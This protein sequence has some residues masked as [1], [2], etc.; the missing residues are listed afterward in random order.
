MRTF[1]VL[2]AVGCSSTIYEDTDTDAGPADTSDPDWSAVSDAFDAA[3]PNA[4]DTGMTLVLW[5]AD[6]QVVY[7]RTAGGFE[8]DVRVPVASASKLVSALLLL[9]MVDQGQLSLTDTTGEVLGWTGQKRRISLDHLGGFTS[10]FEGTVGC[11]YNATLSLQDCTGRM[12]DAGPE[13]QPGALFEYTNTHLHIAGA[14]AEV[15]GGAS[16]NALFQRDLAKPLGLTSPDLRYYTL[17]KRLLG[18]TNPL[19]AGGMVSSVDE[20]GAFLQLILN[21]GQVDGA[22]FIRPDL[23]DRLFTNAYTDA[24]IGSS[25]VVE[26]G[27]DY[28]YGFG[29]W[30]ECEG[31]PAQCDILNSAGSFGF[32]PW[33]DRGRGYAGI[34]AMEGDTGSV[35]TFGLPLQQ[36]LRPLIEAV[37]DSPAE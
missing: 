31:A 37:L 35:L 19:V 4:P 7:R 18:D 9:R 23:I 1:L 28:R 14:M 33:V 10:G 21:K 36:E 30:L 13:Q 16:W 6:G 26:V 29:S 12:D 27:L 22:P 24:E 32:V 2:L 25:P 20:Y 5:D 11:T 3:A 15:K 8:P 17:P 34:L